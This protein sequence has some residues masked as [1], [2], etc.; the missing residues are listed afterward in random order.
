MGTA[1]T[2]L[3]MRNIQ[4]LHRGGGGG[5]YDPEDDK[6]MKWFFIVVLSIFICFVCAIIIDIVF[7]KEGESY[8]V[9]G[10][11]VGY[12]RTSGKSQKMTVYLLT[13]D[14]KMYEYST[15]VAPRA[16]TKA[17]YGTTIPVK[18]RVFTNTVWG[19]THKRVELVANPCMWT[20]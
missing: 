9:D 7:T 18:T 3:I 15:G 11:V 13:K 4:G 16:C 5:S 12:D 1:A 20:N 8:I 17:P 14:G 19:T 10:E 2:I 6:F